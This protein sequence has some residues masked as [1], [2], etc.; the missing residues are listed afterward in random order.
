MNPFAELI[1]FGVD[2][3]KPETLLAFRASEESHAYA[4]DL[5]H[6]EKT[7]MVTQGER[8]ETEQFIPLEHVA[9]MMKAKARELGTQDQLDN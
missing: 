3:V 5:L 6:K 4:C 1:D 7:G 2:D 9:R 8:D